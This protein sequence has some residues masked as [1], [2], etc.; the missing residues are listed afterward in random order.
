P[1]E[2]H[3]NPYVDTLINFRYF[4]V[5]KMMFIK[6]STAFLIFPGGFGTLD[7]LFEAL[8]LIQ[9]GKIYQFPVILFCRHYWAGLVRWLQ[10]RALR[11]GKIA[12]SDIDLLMMT[13]DPGQAAKVVLDAYAAQT[14]LAAERVQREGER[15]LARVIDPEHA[16]AAGRR[17]DV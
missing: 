1:F 5:R 17:R 12:A 10:A 9:T 11:E 4:L 3:A 13:D 8:T 16:K 6:Y 7:E 2:Q 15:P 14:R